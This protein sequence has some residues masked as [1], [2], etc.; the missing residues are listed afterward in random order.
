MPTPALPYLVQA[1]E[2]AEAI[3]APDN[4]SL[5]IICLGKPEQFLSGH[6]PG[7]VWL[8]QAKL[9]RGGMPAPG[10]LPDPDILESA[11]AEIGLGADHHVVGYDD[12]GGTGGARLIWVLEAMGHRRLSMLDGGLESWQAERLP[13][14]AGIPATAPA[15][16]RWKAFPDPTVVATKDDVLSILGDPEVRILDARSEGEYLGRKTRSARKGRIPGARHLNWL[17]TIDP[18]NNRRLRSPEVLE[19]MLADRGFDR[20]HEIIVHCQTHQ[21]SSHSFVMLRSLGYRRVRAYAGSWMEWAADGSLPVILEDT[22][23]TGGV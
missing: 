18:E 5:R 4:G 22:A 3:A 20:E 23:G 15:A 1:G 12:D 21:R 8:D 9:N 14:E 7:G 11:F 10:L 16:G 19:K 6:I 13:L 17:D 2:L